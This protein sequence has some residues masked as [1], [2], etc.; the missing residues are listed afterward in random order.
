MEFAHEH[1]LAA[2]LGRG[3]VKTNP[4]CPVVDAKLKRWRI[5]AMIPGDFRGVTGQGIAGQSGW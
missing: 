5:D 1:H 4:R 3:Y 2:F